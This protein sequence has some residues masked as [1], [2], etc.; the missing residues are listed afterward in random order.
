MKWPSIM[1]VSH[2]T[3]NLQMYTHNST[4]S[5]KILGPGLNHPTKVMGIYCIP[6]NT[7]VISEKGFLYRQYKMNVVVHTFLNNKKVWVQRL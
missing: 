1:S 7:V 6:N 5:I 3:M 4:H 2:V